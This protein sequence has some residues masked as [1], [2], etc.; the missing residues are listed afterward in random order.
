MFHHKAG[1]AQATLMPNFLLPTMSGTLSSNLFQK[2]SAFFRQTLNDRNGIC[3]FVSLLCVSMVH[4]LAHISIVD[5]RR[6][7]IL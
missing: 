7:I 6:A 3:D 1:I 4:P 5:L 2:R